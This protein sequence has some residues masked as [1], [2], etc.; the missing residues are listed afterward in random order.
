MLKTTA[1]I[2]HY[3]S[4]AR[5]TPTVRSTHARQAA[6]GGRTKNGVWRSVGETARAVWCVVGNGASAHLCQ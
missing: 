4:F 2:D 1:A 6:S 3:H 5:T